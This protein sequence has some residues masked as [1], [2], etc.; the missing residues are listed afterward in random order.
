MSRSRLDI[1]L[2][3]RI[4]PRIISNLGLFLNLSFKNSAN[5]SS[6]S[7]AITFLAFSSSFSVK[8]PLPGP[9]SKTISSGPTSPAETISSAIF[10]DFKKFC[11]NDFLGLLIPYYIFRLK[12][13]LLHFVKMVGNVGQKSGR[14]I[15]LLVAINRPYHAERQKEI[16][17][18]PGYRHVK[19][20]SFFFIPLL[21][22]IAKSA[23]RK[24]PL[25][26]PDNENIFEFQTFGGVDSHQ[27]DAVF[28]FPL[29]AGRLVHRVLGAHQN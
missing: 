1:G 26:Q 23:V 29:P 13:K 27:P 11:P 21:V 28:F 20:S 24:Q 2:N 14:H 9:T 15:H 8:I 3:F 7:T 22:P 25:F 16:F 17:F 5:S 12:L 10:S 6:F 19:Q 4:S 18:R